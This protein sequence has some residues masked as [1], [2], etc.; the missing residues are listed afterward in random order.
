[1][2]EIFT[3]MTIFGI[4]GTIIVTWIFWIHLPIKMARNR[5]RSA[6]GWVLIFWVTS[7][8]VGIILLLVLGDSKEKIA[9]DIMDRIGRR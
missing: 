8:L 3:G 2:I 6:L 7:P 5:G 9:N 1:M 4:I